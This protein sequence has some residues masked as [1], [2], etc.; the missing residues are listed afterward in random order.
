VPHGSALVVSSSMPIRDIDAF[1]RP[2]AGAPVVYSNRGANGI[3]GVSSTVRGVA[4]VRAGAGAKGAPTIGFL[5]E[6]AFLHDLSA[7][8]IG[9]EEKQ[10]GVTFVVIDNHGGGIFSFLPYAGALRRDVFVRAFATPQSADIAAVA[11]AFGLGVSEIDR[12]AD[13]APALAAAGASG[14]DQ[15]VLVRTD[16]GRNVEIH[17]EIDIAVEAAIVRAL[18]GS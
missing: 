15:L 2:R 5:G 14:S 4:F 6:L 9:A 12:R 11:T 13:F 10:V 8:V 17:A 1:A 3:D 7:H 18:S 16:P